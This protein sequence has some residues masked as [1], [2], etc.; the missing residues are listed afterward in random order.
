MRIANDNFSQ[1]DKMIS[2][3]ISPVLTHLNYQTEMSTTKLLPSSYNTKSH[4]IGSYKPES[5]TISNP[6][7]KPEKV[8]PIKMVA[9]GMKSPTQTTYRKDSIEYLD[10]NRTVS[11]T[12]THSP[13]PIADYRADNHL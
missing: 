9:A 1:S 11:V 7:S 5:R 4:I 2:N 6:R 10:R 3:S 12:F 8:D 13:T